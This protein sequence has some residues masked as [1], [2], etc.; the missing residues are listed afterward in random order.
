MF[1]GEKKLKIN[2]TQNETFASNF[3]GGAV[4]AQA[5][6]ATTQVEFLGSWTGSGQLKAHLRHSFTHVLFKLL[7]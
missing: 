4:L 3:E 2:R 1:M 5:H 7:G 6:G